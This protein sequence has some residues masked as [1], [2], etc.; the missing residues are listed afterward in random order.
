MCTAES[1]RYYVR[2]ITD[3]KINH[4]L[5]AE[6]TL[7]RPKFVPLKIFVAVLIL[8]AL[9]LLAVLA[10]I[11]IE[12]NGAIAECSQQELVFVSIFWLLFFFSLMAARFSILM[13]LLYQRYAQASVRLRCRCV[14][15]C[16]QYAIIAFK[17]Y[18]VSY[19]F[20]KMIFH[21]KMCKMGPYYEFP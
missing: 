18:G 1:S 5:S 14:P 3:Y 20:Y 13:I 2:R 6:V 7:Y 19:G 4:L 16:S 21:L 17:K 10:T 12:H 15:S 8:I 9:I 11:S